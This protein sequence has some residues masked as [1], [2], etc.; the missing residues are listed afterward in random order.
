MGS[1]VYGYELSGFIKGRKFLDH[2]SK[3][4]NLELQKITWQPQNVFIAIWP[5]KLVWLHVYKHI[6]MWYKWYQNLQYQIIWNTQICLSNS[7]FL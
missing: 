2:L 7:S 6:Y 5:V 1:F 3:Y 4:W